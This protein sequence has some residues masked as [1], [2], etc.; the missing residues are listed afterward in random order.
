MN[1][2][3]LCLANNSCIVSPFTV[4]KKKFYKLY[5]RKANTHHYTQF[6]EMEEFDNAIDSL[7]NV[8]QKYKD[9][10]KLRYDIQRINPI[11]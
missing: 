3:L 2:S 7:E 9:C 8:I 6:M 11:M 10:E 1:T 5:K 4:L